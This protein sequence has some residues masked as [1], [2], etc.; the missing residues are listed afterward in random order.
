MAYDSGKG[1][2]QKLKEL[3]EQ[4]EKAFVAERHR[5]EDEKSKKWEDELA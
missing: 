4:A 1:E 3:M 2:V 5:C